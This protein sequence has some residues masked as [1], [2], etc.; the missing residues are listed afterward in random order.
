[1]FCLGLSGPLTIEYG[2]TELFI[3]LIVCLQGQWARLVQFDASKQHKHVVH[4]R[5]GIR[6]FCSSTDTEPQVL[7]SLGGR[8]IVSAGSVNEADFYVKTITK[9][10]YA[11]FNSC[12]PYKMNESHPRTSESH[13]TTWDAVSQHVNVDCYV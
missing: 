13:F 10:W 7:G 3:T 5:S 4:S 2:N 12:P 6:C 1:M 11:A 8:D 9:G